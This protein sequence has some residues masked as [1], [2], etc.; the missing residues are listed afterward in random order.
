MPRSRPTIADTSIEVNS[1][2]A[3]LKIRVKKQ[4]AVLGA[5]ACGLC[6]AE[7]M[8]ESGFEVTNGWELQ[9]PLGP[10]AVLGQH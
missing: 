4:V 6:A 8:S 9:Q 1:G 7:T 5:G 2:K 10:L 3:M